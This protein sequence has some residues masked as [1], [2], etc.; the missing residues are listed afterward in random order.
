MV[1][2]Q[3]GAD[4]V[5]L[6]CSNKIKKSLDRD[7]VWSI[8]LLD[9]AILLCFHTNIVDLKGGVVSPLLWCFL[10]IYS[11]ENNQITTKI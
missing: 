6:P 4:E 10:L 2:R 9:I 7:N 11:S 3:Q 1:V 5:K 8:M